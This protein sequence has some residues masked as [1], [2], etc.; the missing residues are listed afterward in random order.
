MK[1]P[2]QKQLGQLEV[3]E[4]K[5]GDDFPYIVLFHGYGANAFDLMP[6]HQVIA[7]N[8]KVNWLFPQGLMDVHLG[9]GMMGKAWFPIDV[10]AFERAMMQGELRDLSRTLPE[11]FENARNAAISMLKALKVPLDKIVIGGFSQGAMLATDLSLRFMKPPLASLIL[12]GTLLDEK[13]WQK[14]CEQRAG[15][16]LFQS[17]GKSDPLLPFQMAQRLHE[18]FTSA[19][20]DASFRPFQG[21][22]EIPQSVVTDVNAFLD[23]I[24]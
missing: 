24:L 7:T 10:E 13:N 8:K 15:Y 2:T 18:V 3:Y 16:K 1:Q 23:D 17:H 14:L 5:N 11:G 12:S 21:G 4:I 9:M 22:H 6:L 20:L 19:N